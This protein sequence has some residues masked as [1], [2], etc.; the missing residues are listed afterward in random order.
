MAT[1]DH[2]V[3]KGYLNAD[4]P[5]PVMIHRLGATRCGCNDDKVDAISTLLEEAKDLVQRARNSPGGETC[6]G[7]TLMADEANA[8]LLYETIALW[9][10]HVEA[11]MGLVVISPDG[12][13]NA[14]DDGRRVGR[15]SYKDGTVAFG[16]QLDGKWESVVKNL[17][18][19]FHSIA[20]ARHW[21][22]NL[23]CRRSN[24]MY[25]WHCL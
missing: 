23:F 8:Q 13:V 17:K 20:T 6:N 7:Q 10:L 3:V 12:T 14:T 22:V 2:I 9:E 1:H 25:L 15:L 11:I 24:H 19:R 21:Y 16:R 5:P 4:H 18:P